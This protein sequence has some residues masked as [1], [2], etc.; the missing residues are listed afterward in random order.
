MMK[1][2]SPMNDCHAVCVQKAK[3]HQHRFSLLV[4]QLYWKTK[5]S[6]ISCSR[7]IWSSPEN[8]QP[9]HGHW[10]GDGGI[11]LSIVVPQLDPQDI[12]LFVL[13]VFAVVDRVVR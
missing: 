11:V 6:A 9:T 3:H 12:H 5:Q 10:F 8:I 7:R 2:I 4:A 13:L 1:L